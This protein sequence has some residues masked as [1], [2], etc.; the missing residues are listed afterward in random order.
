MN[1]LGIGPLEI[2]LVLILIL[3]IFG[4]KDLEKTGKS[5][6]QTLY[7]LI[8]SDAWRNLQQTSREIKNLP[9][10]L[11]REASLDELKKSTSIELDKVSAEIKKSTLADLGKIESEIKKSTSIEKEPEK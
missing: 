9:N 6:G 3:V 1:I 5:I 11:I 4:P 10:R 7:K 2:V 8:H